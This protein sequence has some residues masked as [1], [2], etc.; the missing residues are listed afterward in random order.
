MHSFS[1]R[2]IVGLSIYIRLQ[3]FNIDEPSVF[4]GACTHTR[5]SQ[6]WALLMVQLPIRNTEQITLTAV[7]EAAGQTEPT[8]Y[9]PDFHR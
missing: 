7:T 9:I 8:F 2:Y 3:R 1:K 6:G 5:A 4:T